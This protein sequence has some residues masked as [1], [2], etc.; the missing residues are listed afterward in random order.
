M[1]AA[2]RAFPR[3]V[4][5]ECRI[6]R[7]RPRDHVFRRSVNSTK[8]VTARVEG[9]TSALQKR[10]SVQPDLDPHDRSRFF[11]GEEGKRSAQE[12]D[13]ARRGACRR[14]VGEALQGSALHLKRKGRCTQARQARVS[15]RA[16]TAAIR[17]C[18]RMP[19]LRR[20]GSRSCSRRREP[21]GRSSL[22]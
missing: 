14:R 11:A 8:R 20:D 10:T 15:S 6:P 5:S 9:W 7:E 18:C 2:V 3:R 22:S 4:S 13:A 16:P 12:H 19:V 17:S 1:E 21:P